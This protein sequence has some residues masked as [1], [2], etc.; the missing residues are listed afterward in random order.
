VDESDEPRYFDRGLVQVVPTSYDEPAAHRRSVNQKPLVV[1]AR[2]K[3]RVKHEA[4]ARRRV[5]HE[6]S[7]DAMGFLDQ[8]R[9]HGPAHLK[10]DHERRSIIAVGDFEIVYERDSIITARYEFLEAVQRVAPEA[11]TELGEIAKDQSL[12]SQGPRLAE[13]L[14]P[15]TRIG[16]CLTI[17]DDSRL[18]S[19]VRG[20]RSVTSRPLGAGRKLASPF[21]G[22]KS[23][24]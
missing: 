24:R 21:C 11:F 17:S 5:I 7:P 6:V 10:I 9:L 15:N 23:P 22:M 1:A 14:F 3:R 13:C 18:K 2:M 20:G 8:M 4:P 16:I 19:A 12:E